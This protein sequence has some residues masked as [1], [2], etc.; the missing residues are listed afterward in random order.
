MSLPELWR[1]LLPEE[2]QWLQLPRERT[3]DCAH[4]PKVVT[5]EYRSECRCCTYYPQIPNFLLGLALKDPA[6]RPHI[7]AVVRSGHVLPTGMQMTPAHYYRS[8]Q[9]YKEEQFGRSE[10]ILCPFMARDSGRCRIHG[11]RNSVCATFYCEHDHGDAGATYWG[12]V[13]ALLGQIELVLAQWT[14]GKA[15]M[16]PAAYVARLNGLSE[17]VASTSG[18]VPNVWSE[19]VLRELWGEHF[20]S[21]TAFLEA[22]A[23]AAN[24]RKDSLYE[25]ACRQ[26]LRSTFQFEKAVERG[27]PAACR[28]EIQALPSERAEPVPVSDLWYKLQ[29]AT[30]RLWAVPFN[31]GELVLNRAVTIQP[32]PTNTPLSKQYEAKPFILELPNDGAALLPRFLSADEAALLAVFEKPQVAG[33]ALMAHPAVS[34]VEAAREFLAVCLRTE[35]LLHR[36]GA[37]GSES[38]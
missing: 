21:E 23:D 14:M 22:C 19:D 8:L 2:Y 18:R 26:E 30:R 11:Y 16:D 35:V 1:F 12:R 36:E 31:D 13:Q 4:C 9:L 15:G 17:S 29:L 10:E 28:E 3:A 38:K 34:A 20:G 24:D 27:V 33:E 5:G 37:N 32:N 7:E 25:I 6:A